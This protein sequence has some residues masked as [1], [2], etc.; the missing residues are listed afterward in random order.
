MGALQN[1]ENSANEKADEW[2]RS[3]FFCS[4]GHDQL[5]GAEKLP[6]AIRTW[7]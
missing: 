5:S 4:V 3:R 7:A 6:A 2:G 1:S